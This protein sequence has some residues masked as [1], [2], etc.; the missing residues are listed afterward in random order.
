MLV[1]EATVKVPRQAIA[2][3]GNEERENPTVR[4]R[5]MSRAPSIHEGKQDAAIR[6]P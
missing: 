4:R 1:I 5:T 6:L 2:S 3:S